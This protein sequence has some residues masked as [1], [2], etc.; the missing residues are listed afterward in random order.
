MWAS[1]RGSTGMCV[2]VVVVGYQS[3][4]CYLDKYLPVINHD[5]Y[6][7]STLE[8]RAAGELRAFVVGLMMSLQNVE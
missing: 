2:L 6:I 7:T 1:D 4:T 8:Y 3:K 5:V